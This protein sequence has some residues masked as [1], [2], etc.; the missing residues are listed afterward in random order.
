MFGKFKGASMVAL[1]AAV[2]A[3]VASG[4]V[5]APASA[6]NT[7]TNIQAVFSNDAAPA[8]PPAGWTREVSPSGF[9]MD[10]YADCYGGAI[11]VYNMPSGSDYSFD[12]NGYGY[13]FHEP[14]TGTIMLTWQWVHAGTEY[15]YYSWDFEPSGMLY[16][17]NGIATMLQCPPSS[18]QASPSSPS[19]NT[20]K[21]YIAARQRCANKRPV[22]R[23]VVV[24]KRGKALR[25]ARKRHAS[26]YMCKRK[27]RRS[28]ASG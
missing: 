26:L 11:K 4:L 10:R 27:S 7:A 16:G 12:T 3:L 9:I 19:A 13:K 15:L 6:A 22:G 23:W 2:F 1:I 14:F 8:S 20:D 18:W 21:A 17:F 5:M 25:I 28:I 24:K